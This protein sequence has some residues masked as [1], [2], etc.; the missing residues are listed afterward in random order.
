MSPEKEVVLFILDYLF[1]NSA[2][3]VLVI[4]KI[5]RLGCLEKQTRAITS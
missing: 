2:E 4:F 5:N 1:F 3:V